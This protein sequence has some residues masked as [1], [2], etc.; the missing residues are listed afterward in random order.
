MFS[1]S[2]SVPRLLPLLASTG[3]VLATG[4]AHGLASAPA[5]LD[6]HPDLVTSIA[7]T[8]DKSAIVTG[9]RDG[10]VRLW[11]AQAKD[12]NTRAPL[13]EWDTGA[14]GQIRAVAPRPGRATSTV[15]GLDLNGQAQLFIRSGQN[16][17]QTLTTKAAVR[18]VAA[19]PADN[20]K[21]VAIAARDFVR[22]WGPG[23]DN[24]TPSKSKQLPAEANAIAWGSDGTIAAA[25]EA[26]GVA[27]WPGPSADVTK[28]FFRIETLLP[29]TALALRTD[30][31]GKTTLFTADGSAGSSPGGRV[32]SW[33]LPVTSPA[34][35]NGAKPG[36]K[37]LA[38]SGDGT[39]IATAVDGSLQ[40]WTTAQLVGNMAGTTIALPNLSDTVKA[41]ALSQDGRRVA[42]AVNGAP[43][44][45][46][47][48]VKNGNPPPTKVAKSSTDVNALAFRFDAATSPP[49][50]S[51]AWAGKAGMAK[52]R[53]QYLSTTDPAPLSP[54]DPVNLGAVSDDPFSALALSG[55]GATLFVAVPAAP[56]LAR[57]KT[58]DGT[59]LAD[60]T[61][62]VHQDKVNAL[63]LRPDG[64]QLISG[65]S[66]GTAKVWDV[67]GA[68]ANLLRTVSFD[69]KRALK[70][71]A[72]AKSGDRVAAV[73][74]DDLV[75]LSDLN[76]LVTQVWSDPAGS[77]GVGTA[78]LPDPPT[79]VIGVW[80]KNVSLI[81][82]SAGDVYDP[83][84]NP[85]PALTLALDHQGKRL[86]VGHNSSAPGKVRLYDLGAPPSSVTSLDAHASPVNAVV[87]TPDDTRLVTGSD[88]GTVLVWDVAGAMP[89]VKQKVTTAKG[90]L[91]LVAPDNKTAI[92]GLVDGSVGTVDLDAG[93]FTAGIGLASDRIN[94]LALLSG[95]CFPPEQARLIIGSQ[96]QTVSLWTLPPAKSPN[97][98]LKIPDTIPP[99]SST[100]RCAAWLSLGAAPPTQFVTG[101]SDGVVRIW[102]ITQPKA[103]RTNLVPAPTTP[104]SSFAVN[105]VVA[106]DKYLIVASE[107]RIIRIWDVTATAGPVAK[108]AGHTNQVL[109]LAWSTN[110]LA[111]G[112]VDTTVRLWDADASK[113]NTDPVP[114]GTG[115]AGH[116]G[117][118]TTLAFSPDGATLA[119]G[120]DTGTIIFWKVMDGTSL[121]KIPGAGNLALGLVWNPDGTEVAVAMEP[122]QVVFFAKP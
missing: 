2:G 55:D 116:T 66:D 15:L 7:W 63:A 54:P 39:T 100:A 105:A 56:F 113:L 76:V 27:L 49:T 3:L 18:A 26:E 13:K 117:G 32:R 34:Q 96:D 36:V 118:V 51:L 122:D 30:S 80:E 46:Y 60:F 99:A 69:D 79:R 112:S 38:V 70:A 43:E 68:N 61:G 72:I 121:K 67:T 85:G 20:R 93:K 9:C 110:I 45:I 101:G 22:V 4:L 108:A 82:P 114:R 40:F 119:S 57:F 21:Q 106:I 29:V 11:D 115:L 50:V 64:Q 31:S 12:R 58:A 90:V 120:D 1:T 44:L 37:L 89:T 102:D 53:V 47:Y 42:C 98:L 86:A 33:S 109:S 87:F 5:T 92:A 71:V 19:D 77:S 83:G 81:T 97:A 62:T 111:S 10:K 104:P 48:E 73:T 52:H 59:Q 103:A 6:H 65:S 75:R 41:L 25:V 16:A 84:D 78:I 23:P 88:D 95:D 8:P 35:A 107:K 28:D 24:A 17:R 74:D 94:A 14:P 91:S